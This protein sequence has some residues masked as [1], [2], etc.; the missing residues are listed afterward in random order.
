MSDDKP[1]AETYI[2]YTT[3]TTTGE[4]RSLRTDFEFHEGSDY[5]WREGNGSCDCNRGAWFDGR[6][7]PC[8]EG[9]FRVRCLDDAGNVLYEDEEGSA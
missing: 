2:V 5:F 6:K 1:L 4:T 9:R 3:D 8:G 7:R